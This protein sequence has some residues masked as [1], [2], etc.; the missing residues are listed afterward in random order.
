MWLS[1]FLITA[2]ISLCLCAAAVTLEEGG[3]TSSSEAS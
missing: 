1:L 3:L 2:A